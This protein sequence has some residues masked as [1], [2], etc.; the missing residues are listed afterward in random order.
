MDKNLENNLEQN[1]IASDT[2]EFAVKKITPLFW[3]YSLFGLAGLIMQA[4]SVIADGFFVGNGVGAIGLATIGIIASMWTV[5]VALMALFGIGGATIIA[6]KIG[7]GDIEGARDA[8]A[9]ITIF[10][11]FLSLLISILSLLNVESILY[12]LGATDDIIPYAKDYAIPYFIGLPFCVTGGAVYYYPRALGK[13]L[14]STLAYVVP[15]IVATITEYILIFKFDFGM[16]GSA[17]S[18]VICVGA[19]FL[20]IFYLQFTKG[21]FKIK[22]SD[23]KI[24]FNYV[25][26]AIQIGFAIF[27]IELSVLLTTVIINRQIINYGG[28][29][30][31]I[32]AYGMVNAYIVYIILLLCNSLIS[33]LLPIA[34]F[35]EGKKNYG[36]LKELV[37]KATVQSVIALTALLIVIF[38]FAEPIVAFFAGPDV[39]LIQ[40]TIDIMKVYLP[41][42]TLGCLALLVSGY[43]QALERNGIAI[44]SGLMRVVI[45]A[46][47]LLFILPAVVGFNGIWFAQP[48]A[49]GLAFIVSIILIR[50]EMKSLSKLEKESVLSDNVVS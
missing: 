44:F 24:K 13:P 40:P 10:T 12:F 20:L 36:R 46:T 15:A 45:F 3:K 35:N 5:V 34:S 8:Y 50:R 49:D 26:N 29:E 19:A 22:L 27:T 7:E 16:K 28:S 11:F 9:A 1:V 23:F 42:Y 14:A 30:L 2:D 17:L 37:K 33:G 32:A 4:C 18:W 21:G 41:L 47:P 38:I 48:V 39:D 31:E 43:Y 25:W 6:N